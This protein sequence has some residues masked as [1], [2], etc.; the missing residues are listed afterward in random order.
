MGSIHPQNEFRRG[1]APL[2]VDTVFSGSKDKGQEFSENFF[3]LK[4]KR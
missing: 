1:N 4:R 2:D 3:G